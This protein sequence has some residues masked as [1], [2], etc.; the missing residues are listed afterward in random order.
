MISEIENYLNCREY[1]REKIP[2][3][4]EYFVKYY[5]EETEE[6]DTRIKTRLVD[7]LNMNVLMN[8][9]FF[10]CQ[11]AIDLQIQSLSG[12]VNGNDIELILPTVIEL[13]RHRY[14]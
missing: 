5:G 10:T 4:T 11:R 7:L 3:V 9:K 6:L 12:V 13:E 2:V 8:G 1:F 14:E